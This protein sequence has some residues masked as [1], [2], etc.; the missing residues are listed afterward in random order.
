M[1]KIIKE[2]IRGKWQEINEKVDFAHFGLHI[3]DYTGLCLGTIGVVVFGFF[4]FMEV[5]YSPIV[6]AEYRA[7]VVADADLM[8]SL[9]RVWPILSSAIAFIL[10]VGG[11]GWSVAELGASLSF[12]DSH[13]KRIIELR[14]R[15]NDAEIGIEGNG[16]GSEWL[17]DL[18]FSG[19]QEAWEVANFVFQGKKLGLNVK[20]L[21][22]GKFKD[23]E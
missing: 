4:A 8:G 23:G 11:I 19:S 13:Y 18:E 1:R 15:I 6:M 14:A 10:F 2:L 20:R 16:R 17:K 22:E 12:Y 7:T 21:V 5:A 9:F 3:A